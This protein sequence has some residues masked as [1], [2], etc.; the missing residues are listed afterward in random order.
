M[1]RATLS[2][3][4]G[5]ALAGAAHAEQDMIRLV[6]GKDSL[7]LAGADIISAE[8]TVD[9]IGAPAVSITFSE[10]QGQALAAFTRA[11][12]GVTVDFVICDMLVM[13]PMLMS[14]IP[15]GEILVTGSTPE[16]FETLLGQLRAK[17]CKSLPG[18]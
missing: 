14:E 2:F 8:M 11:H 7:S 1:N 15:G 4:I 18:A 10:K 3:L 5:I 12:V 6:V 17:D 9:Y 16:A 13:Q